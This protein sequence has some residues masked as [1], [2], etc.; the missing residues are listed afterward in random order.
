MS[1]F[2]EMSHHNAQIHPLKELIDQVITGEWGQDD[3]DGTGVSVLRTTNFS[4]DGTLDLS[5]VVTRNIEQ[6]KIETK[7]LIKGDTLLEK[8]GGTNDNPVGRVV[9]FNQEGT[10]LC[11]NFSTVLRCKKDINS[12]FFFYS[13]YVYYQNNKEKIRSMGNKTTGIQNLKME[14]YLETPISVPSFDVQ[15]QF[16]AI[17]K[18]ADKSK[19]ELREAIKR[20]ESMMKSLMN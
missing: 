8:S 2:I 1:R 13:L 14:K 11:N 7:K 20:V 9:Y 15:E 16:E 5:S 6:R 18:Q 17:V 12:T 19:F 4:N 3:V 10:F